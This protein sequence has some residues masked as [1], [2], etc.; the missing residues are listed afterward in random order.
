MRSGR[1]PRD[2]APPIRTIAERGWRVPS[3][4]VAASRA[5]A[6]ARQR[7][8]WAFGTGRRRPSPITMTTATGV[9][10]LIPPLCL[11]C[12]R[13]RDRKRCAFGVA[14]PPHEVGEVNRWEATRRSTRVISTGRAS[15]RRY[16]LST[17][18]RQAKRASGAWLRPGLLR[19]HASR[20]TFGIYRRYPRQLG[21]SSLEA[22]PFIRGP[23]R[24]ERAVAPEGSRPVSYGNRGSERSEERWPVLRLRRISGGGRSRA[25]PFRVLGDRACRLRG[26][27]L[28]GRTSA[29]ERG[30]AGSARAGRFTVDAI[31]LP[32]IL[33][34][35]IAWWRRPESRFR[36]ADGR[37]RLCGLSSR[38][39]P[40]RAWRLPLRDRRSVHDRPGAS[41]L[42]PSSS[43]TCS[44]R[45]RAAGSNG[46]RACPRRGR[47]CHR[48]GLDLVVMMISD[49]GPTTCSASPRSPCRP[50]GA[51]R[52][53]LVA[54]SAL[55]LAGYRGSRR[56]AAEARPAV[57]P[58]ARSADRRLCARPGAIPVAL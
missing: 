40:G 41:L 5:R 18:A 10:Y 22:P 57:A 47:V 53:S 6:C 45:F 44:S 42:P 48:I 27:H 7:K 20:T 1:R 16:I 4:P 15:P 14:P 50:G 33:A 31:M 58:L 26:R 46:V 56:A 54:L 43:C 37:G 28:D 39:S 21:V 12:A 30:P 17:E 9:G 24:P 29:R 32:Y 2:Q 19:E 13:T 23:R 55:S 49:L 38:T 8:W 3:R 34:G 52:F 51:T 11:A 25:A 35:L 36:P